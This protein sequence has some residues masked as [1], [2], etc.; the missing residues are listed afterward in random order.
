LLQ[1]QQ[2]RREDDIT[3]EKLDA[4]KKLVERVL[5]VEC[6]IKDG[7]LIPTKKKIDAKLVLTPTEHEAETKKMEE[8]FRKKV[9][10]SDKQF[11]DAMRELRNSYEGEYR[12]YVECYWY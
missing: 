3:K 12:H 10:E 8:D 9:S 2:R 6:E 5:G 4:T 1:L 7:E 11:E